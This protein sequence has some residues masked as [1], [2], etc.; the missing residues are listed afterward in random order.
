VLLFGGLALV[1]REGLPMRFILEACILTGLVAGLAAVTEIEANPVLFLVAIYCFTMRIRLLVDIGNL[2]AR[3]GYHGAASRIYRLALKLWPDDANRASVQINQ[4]MLDLQTG[5]LDQSIER[6][7][8]ALESG[9]KGTLSLKQESGCHHNL[10][11]AYERMGMDA[12]AERN[13][14][15]RWRHGRA[16]N[17]RSTQLPLSSDAAE[18]EI[19]SIG[20]NDTLFQRYMRV[21]NVEQIQA[22]VEGLLTDA[23]EDSHRL[24]SGANSTFRPYQSGC[25]TANQVGY[26]LSLSIMQSQC[27]L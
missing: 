4:G 15:P 17:S 7:R 22:N 21:S 13:S 1:R 2:I 19:E 20:Q 16:R 27:F 3:N 11:V 6:L 14:E 8:G 5:R 26:T 10:A 25:D 23:R 9:R 24:T 12:E 18:G